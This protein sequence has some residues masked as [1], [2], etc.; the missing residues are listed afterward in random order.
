V[1]APMDKKGKPMEKYIDLWESQSS[2]VEMTTKY[3]SEEVK[4]SDVK[5]CLICSFE[6]YEI[7]YLTILLFIY[8]WYWGLSSGSSS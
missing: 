2:V 1:G 6:E 3:S 4:Q 7:F 8:L 5:T